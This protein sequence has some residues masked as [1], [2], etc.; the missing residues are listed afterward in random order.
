MQDQP[1]K[2]IILFRY[3]KDLEVCRNHLNLLKKLNPEVPIYGLFGGK[4]DEFKGFAKGLQDLLENNYII[5][6]EDGEWK[7]K[8][9]D[10]AIRQWYLDYGN[11]LDFD[12]LYFIE[13]D[14]LLFAPLSEIY[15]HVPDSGV[16]LTGLRPLREVEDKW[17][18]VAK[19]PARSE[20][21]A[22]LEYVKND[23]SYKQ[24]PYG[25]LFPGGVFPKR[26]LE[27][28][29][30]IEFSRLCHDELRVPLF[31][32]VLGFNLFDTKLYG[33]WFD[34]T[35]DIKLFRLFSLLS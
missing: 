14:M 35:P 1:T 24:K 26:F 25:C 23:F 11:K 22:L 12:V 17:N 18:W 13:W 27:E 29:S 2:R 30:K 34:P 3:H 20:W 10:L 5:L 19:E 15:S 8:H 6:V 28:Y 33:E 4:K 7:W 32:Q 21:L 31:A 16:G 9:G